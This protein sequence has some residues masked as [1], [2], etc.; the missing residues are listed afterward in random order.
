MEKEISKVSRI[1]GELRVPSDKSI[2]HRS[3]ILTSLADGVSVVKN[4]LKAGDTLTTLNVY[5]KLGV[6]IIEEKGVLKI[7]GVNLKGFK[8]PEDILDMGNSGTTT[9]LTLGLL[10]GQEFFS[11][12]T[13]DDSLRQRPMGRVADPL[14]SMGAKID[15]R[16]DGK[17]LPLSVR[18]SSLKG[19]QFYNKRSSAQVKSALLIAGLLAEGKTKVT[20]PY[21]SRDHTEKMLDAMGADIHIERDDE[22]SVTIS[23]SKKLEGIE[24]DVPA[25]P[26]SAAFFAAAAVLIPDSELL[27]KDVLINPTRDGFFRKLKEMGGDIRYTNIREKAKE[28]VADIYVRYS[29]DLKGIRIKK[30]DVPSMVDEIPLLSI[31][32]TQAEGETIITGAEELRVKESDR[33]KAVVENLKNL[34]ID[35]EELPDGM[36]IKGKQKVKGG[37][38]DSYK[39]HRIAMGFSIL[40]LISEEGIKIKDADSVFIS[41]PEFYEHLERII[42][43]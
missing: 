6:S 29:P 9:R 19:I 31:V 41:Y 38:V 40:G 42:S 36:V 17:L 33:I 28:P 2:S 14:R 11:A 12:L 22:Y 1:K 3:I 20:E 35:V 37:V 24:I 13:G 10:S 21:I 43:N 27:L 25:D 26:S 32:A 23:G 15:G 5:R 18:G 34:G 4:F 30:E 16:Q 7:K 8:E 39:D